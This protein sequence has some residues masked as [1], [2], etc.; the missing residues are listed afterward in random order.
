MTMTNFI[1]EGA[2][3]II[4]TQQCKRRFPVAEIIIHH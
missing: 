4:A 3:K 2:G 1:D